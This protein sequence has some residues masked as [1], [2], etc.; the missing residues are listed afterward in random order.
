M[1]D[2]ATTPALFTT[3]VPPID[4]RLAGQLLRECYG[5]EGQVTPLPG[6]RDRNFCLACADGRQMMARF[7]N[8]AE[9]AQEIDFQTAMLAHV[10][11]HNSSLPVPRLIS[12]LDGNLQPQI[13]VNEVALS[14]RVVS[15]LPGTPQHRQAPNAAFMAQLGRTLAQLDLALQ[16]FHHPGAQRDLLWDITHPE[17]LAP[18]LAVINDAEQQRL[19]RRVLENH[20]ERVA[21]LKFS[22]RRQVIHNDLNP[23]NV[24]ADD[25]GTQVSGIIDFGDALYAPMI[26]DLATALAYQLTNEA[27][28]LRLA[29]PFIHAYHQALPLTDTELQVLPD[30][31]ATRL[32]LT[33]T[34]AGWRATLYPG[35]RDYIL[36][37][38]PP[39]WR[40][41]SRLMRL[42]HYQIC[43]Q[44]RAAAHEEKAP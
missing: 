10:A 25:S 30:L 21:P 7:I 12:A 16:S 43:E 24:L 19:I 38:V 11:A 41:L 14:V 15:Y 13:N 26:N 35:N 34:I 27:D 18:K 22:V 20:H 1:S 29:R 37:N 33:I 42:S 44:L 5:L 4:A 2:L 40:N 3:D 36:R 23:H 9:A 8:P 6:E 39:A 32:C 28:P 17:R 31:I